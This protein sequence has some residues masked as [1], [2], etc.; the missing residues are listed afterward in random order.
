[1]VLDARDDE[2]PA[3]GPLPEGQALERQVVRL[4]PAAREDDRVLVG[5]AHGVGERAPRLLQRL[6]GGPPGLVQGAGIP[7]PGVRRDHGRQDVGVERRRGVMVQI[8]VH[9]IAEDRPAGV[10]GGGMGRT[11]GPG[12]EQD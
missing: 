1:V 3:A 9:E 7:E 5:R 12:R 8:H 4:G 6:P 2:V 10:A 11:G